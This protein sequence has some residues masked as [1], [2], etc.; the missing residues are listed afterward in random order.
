[1]TVNRFHGLLIESAQGRSR[2]DQ[3]A[4]WRALHAVHPEITVT[5]SARSKLRE[6]IDALVHHGLAELPRGRDG[7]DNSSAPP[8]PQWLRLCSRP[9]QREKRDLRKVP[10]APELRFLAGARIDLDSDA[11]LQ[12]QGFFA[13]GGRNLPVVPI[14]ERSLHIFGDEK[15]LDSLYSSSAVFGTGRLTLE[16]LRCTV[17]PEPLGWK[18]GPMAEGAIVVLENAATWHSFCRWNEL[19]RQFSAVVYGGGNRFTESVTSLHEIA[20][21]V[22]G[23]H[24]VV[25]FGDLDSAGLSIPQRASRRAVESGLPP[26]QPYR[27]GYQWL[28]Q[29]GGAVDDPDAVPD[30]QLCDWLGDLAEAAWSVVS[31]RKRIPQ[32]R[33]GWEFLQHQSAAT[34]ISREK[35]QSA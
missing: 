13:K 32:E 29:S 31:V 15:R 20:R 10:W 3:E 27:L 12:L 18:R 2:I 33:I 8:L 17:V 11:L 7:W 6:L 1:M 14:K 16:Q 34:E 19:I 30:R 5:T 4:L 22:G 23:I 9:R 26:V 28:L 25:Y 21:E 35:A 24:E